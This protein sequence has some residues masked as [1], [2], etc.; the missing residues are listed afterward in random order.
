L[1]SH[2]ADRSGERLAEVFSSMQAEALETKTEKG[3]SF[4][5]TSARPGKSPPG[6]KKAV[7]REALSGQREK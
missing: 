6:F 1:A 3:A 4:L 2:L 7:D 5:W